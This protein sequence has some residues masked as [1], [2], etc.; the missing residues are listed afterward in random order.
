[1]GVVD[2]GDEGFAGAGEPALHAER[3]GGG[4]KGMAWGT[5]T[6]FVDGA[7]S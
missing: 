5:R 6:A 4:V 2:D 7:G 3:G 1:V